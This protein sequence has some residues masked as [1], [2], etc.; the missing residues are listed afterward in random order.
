MVSERAYAPAQLHPVAGAHYA[1]ASG[2]LRDASVDIPITFIEI[3]PARLVAYREIFYVYVSQI[4]A[5]E[6]PLC[7][8]C[9]AD[10][11]ALHDGG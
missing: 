2:L 4:L 10:I 3:L 6:I 11:P 8:V 5:H 1:A 9:G 7:A